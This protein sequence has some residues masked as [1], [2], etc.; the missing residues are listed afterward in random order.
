[1]K[2]ENGKI[3]QM[4]LSDKTYWMN[5]LQAL[6]KAKML[7]SKNKDLVSVRKDKITILLMP[8][9]KAKKL[10]YKLIN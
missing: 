3:E 2:S 1:M 5:A 4:A 8:K 9:A 10:G 6:A 7:E